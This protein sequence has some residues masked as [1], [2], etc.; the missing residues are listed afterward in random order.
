MRKTHVMSLAYSGSLGVYPLHRPHILITGEYV[1][2]LEE[3]MIWR[4]LMFVVRTCMYSAYN[5]LYVNTQ[6]PAA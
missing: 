1:D 6:Q 3:Q 4:K 5:F 2:V